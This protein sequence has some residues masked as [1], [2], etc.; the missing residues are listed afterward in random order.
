MS[1]PN[2]FKRYKNKIDTELKNHIN[3]RNN[4]IYITH[5]YYMGWDD[6]DG[7]YQNYI[8]KRFRPTLLLISSDAVNGNNEIA[9]K[10]AIALEYVHNFSLIHDDLEDRD[11]YRHHRPTIWT[12]WGENAAII[13]GNGMLKISDEIMNGLISLGVGTQNAINLQSE[14]TKSYLK[15]MEGQYLDITY[16]TIP[17]ISINQYLEMIELKTGALIE[18]AMYLGS[19]TKIKNSNRKLNNHMKS[20][21]HKFGRIYQIRDDILGVWGTNKTGKPVGAD[22]YRKKKSLPAVHALNSESKYVKDKMHS[23]FSSE[24]IDK[25]NVENILDLMEENNTF[26]YCQT[27]AEHYWKQAIEI[28]KE[29]NISKNSTNDLIELGEF[30]LYRES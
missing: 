25:N 15:M 17:S 27:L 22:L 20:I 21:G 1:L 29:I 8:G 9:T 28:I 7:K 24:N 13:S 11:Q 19:L 14:I 30:L 18:S 16:E 10:L 6:L 12:I 4:P 5:K 3:F 2:C 23:I 26:R